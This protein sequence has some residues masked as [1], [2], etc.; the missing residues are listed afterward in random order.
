[1]YNRLSEGDK[2]V[3]TWIAV[4]ALCSLAGV[5]AA[6][7]LED[8]YTKLKAAVANKDPDA[9]KSA[10]ADTLKL[11]KAAQTA[12]KPT[13]AEEVDN[14]K[15]RIEYGKEV[16][17]Y[18]EYALASVAAQPGVDPAKTIDLVDT[19]LGQNPKS[20]YLDL[21]VA[22]YATALNKNGG[23]AKMMAGMTK[24]VTG[25]PDNT[26]ALLALVEGSSASPDRALNYANKLI[27]AMKA[28]AKPEGTSEGDWEK[29]KT[30]ALATGYFTAGYVYLQK[31]AWVDC[32]KDMKAAAPLLSGDP[33]RLGTAYYA[34]G[35]CNFQFGKMTNDRTKMQAGV[36]YTEQSSGIK[37]P[38]QDNA[39]KNVAAMK[40]EL[41][42][43][44]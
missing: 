44:R 5:V 41:A 10:A 34:L 43:G 6:D 23:S 14:W 35:V 30:A 16:E 40:K 17:G 31:Q 25:R 11:A 15:Q 8:S 9:V 33:A 27:A 19:L 21:C 38:V 37:S 2:P 7:D 39:F 29:Q 13:E 28:K 42:G 1:M 26:I 32:D 24:V 20:N 12:T 4:L 22:A 36:K 18:T 3:K